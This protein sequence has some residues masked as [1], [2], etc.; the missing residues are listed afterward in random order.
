MT[1]ER[2]VVLLA[3]RQPDTTDAGLGA[4]TRFLA[5]QQCEIVVV[6]VAAHPE[7][8]VAS[9]K[10][11]GER[12]A[13]AKQAGRSL[14]GPGPWEGV[15]AS[16]RQDGHP[17]VGELVGA[18]SQIEESELRRL[19]AEFLPVSQLLVRRGYSTEVCIRLGDPVE[20]IVAESEQ[21]NADLIVMATR[22]RS[23]LSRL[24]SGSTPEG[25]LHR[26]SVPVLVAHAP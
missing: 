10:D 8:A 16:A 22:G 13:D 14:Q 17:T 2:K 26:A 23:G 25:V 5:P 9:V 7:L 1:E 11:R 6:H 15:R 24:V 12:V 20:Q 19:E 21:R 4:A 18:S 3:L